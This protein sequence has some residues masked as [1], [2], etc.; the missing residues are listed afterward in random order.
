ME[1]RENEGEKKFLYFCRF[2]PRFDRSDLTG[3][4]KGE[5]TPDQRLEMLILKS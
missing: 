5:R 2:D 4:I 1:R 3:I